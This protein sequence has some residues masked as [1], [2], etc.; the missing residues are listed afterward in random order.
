MLNKY[1]MK[2]NPSK[3]VFVIREGKFLEF[4]VSSKGIKPNPEF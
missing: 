1:Q 4:L 2:F 3:C